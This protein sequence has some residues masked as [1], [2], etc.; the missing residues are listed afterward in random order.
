MA[1][2]F[3]R[4]QGTQIRQLLHSTAGAA[5]LRVACCKLKKFPPAGGNFKDRAMNC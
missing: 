2:E 4:L 5:I 3:T 1:N